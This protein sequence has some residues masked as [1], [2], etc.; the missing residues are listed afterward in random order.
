MYG[1]L[2]GRGLFVVP[3]RYGS[4]ML[5]LFKQILDQMACFVQGLV[6][7]ALVVTVWLRWHHDT[8][9]CRHKRVIHPRIRVITFVR[10]HGI[11]LQ[12][13]QQ[14]VRFVK[15]TVL[16]QREMKAQGVAW[17]FVLRPRMKRPIHCIFDCHMAP[18]A[19][20]Y[21]RTIVESIMAYSLSLSWLKWLKTRS[22]NQEPIHRDSVDR[23]LG[24]LA[25]AAFAT[26]ALQLGEAS[27]L[28][29]CRVK[30]MGQNFPKYARPFST[31]LHRGAQTFRGP[32]P[33]PDPCWH[34]Y[35]KIGL[36]RWGQWSITAPD[37]AWSGRPADC[38]GRIPCLGGKG[39]SRSCCNR[40]PRWDIRQGLQP[41]AGPS[42]LST[43]A[44]RQLLSPVAGGASAQYLTAEFSHINSSDSVRE[45]SLAGPFPPLV[46]IRKALITKNNFWAD[47]NSSAYSP[48]LCV[49]KFLIIQFVLLRLCWENTSNWDK[50]M[51][52]VQWS[53]HIWMA[54]LHGSIEEKY[55][56]LEYHEHKLYPRPL[57][58]R[59]V[60]IWWR[61]ALEWYD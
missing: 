39:S 59:R 1:P 60:N 13:G 11:C 61:S 22:H 25:Q 26:A 27:P 17:I 42:P 48:S 20:G 30:T 32:Y 9:S 43:R 8:L 34:R 33:G 24:R 5:Y 56:I 44:G 51:G 31:R 18:A 21:A 40:L 36:L 16:P 54:D 29:L 49:K 14:D 23:R 3:R 45:C 57:E 52:W 46:N 53:D 7:V 2:K 35:Q 10:Q 37:T 58:H 6:I 12:V 55:L 28:M 47:K 19:W 38:L 50:F 4:E 41:V 15:I